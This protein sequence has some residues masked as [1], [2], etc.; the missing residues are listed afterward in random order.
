LPE[1]ADI[2]SDRHNLAKMTQREKAVAFRALHTRGRIFVLANAWDAGSARIFEDAGFA[3]IGTSSAGVA[4]TLGYPDG[5]AIPRDEMLFM[6]RRIATTVRV[7]VSVDVE[8][9]YG[10]NDAEEVVKTAEIVLAAGAVGINLEDMSDTGADLTPLDLQIEKIRAV[11]AMAAARDIPVVINARTDAFG[12]TALEPAVR[13]A[14]AIE[15]GNAYLQAGADCVFTPYVTDAAVIA[16]LVRE[17]GGPL[18]ILAVRGVP[19]VP[20]LDGMGVARLSVGSGP[21]RASLALAR[22]IAAELLER[23]AYASFTDDAIPYAEM[24]RLFRR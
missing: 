1:I 11:R 13:L 6:A 19:S 8:A 16:A 18:N 15:R 24:N 17:I 3:S 21:C 14:L 23:G 4:F 12:L 2:E 20:D 5:Q 9:G 10:A 22:R 7:P